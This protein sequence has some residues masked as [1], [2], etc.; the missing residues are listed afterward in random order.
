[1]SPTTQA[2]ELANTPE[3]TADASIDGYVLD[4]ME[5]AVDQASF[6][7]K[8]DIP[9]AIIGPHG[10]GKMY[11]AKVVH[12]ESG[13]EP[14]LIVQIDCRAFRNRKDA[15]RRIQ[16]ELKQSEGKTLV[17]KSPHLMSGDA[18]LKLARQIASR[19]LADVSPPRYLPDVKLVA[20]FPDTLEQLI[21]FGSLSEKLASVFAGFPIHVP[22]IK[23]R[24]QAVLRWAHKILGQECARRGQH[25]KGF[26]EEAEQGML[27]HE[28][29]GNISEIRQ[30]IGQ[31]M[32]A[33]SSAERE[34]ITPVDLGVY[35]DTGTDEATVPA[36]GSFLEV[37]DKIAAAEEEAYTPT[38]AEQLDVALGE[39]VSAIVRAGINEP[40]GIWLADDLVLA[41]KERYS[42][43]LRSTAEL[44]NTNPR[45]ITRWM[46]RIN[47]RSYHR[48]SSSIWCEPRRLAGEWVRESSPSSTSPLELARN[49]LLTHLESLSGS[50]R[51]SSKAEIMGMSIPTYN[52][53]LKEHHG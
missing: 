53:A 17:F 2:S 5:G 24:G 52:K 19:T 27:G 15:I 47:E 36:P 26:T 10:T 11:V 39:A 29:L 7:A 20:L 34:W 14:G 35:R 30:R 40:L 3:P 49:M 16:K 12:Q 46:P 43:S 50:L 9:I 37:T 8:L 51:V 33:A 25:I 18:Q 28:W 1:M 48:H 31:A 13:R 22:P 6:L 23:D 38:L 45:N 32:E 21:K 41:A 42:G 44:L 4:N